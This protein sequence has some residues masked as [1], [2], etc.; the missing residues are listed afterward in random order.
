MKS[1]GELLGWVFR[2]GPQVSSDL[3]KL[4]SQSQANSGYSSHLSGRVWHIK[5]S[6]HE[7][8]L[9]TVGMGVQT[10]GQSAVRMDDLQ[11]GTSHELLGWLF[12]P[13]GSLRSA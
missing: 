4:T 2:A 11:F 13:E 5:L 3:R 6:Q 7:K 12:R 9:R 10:R 8:W 1:G